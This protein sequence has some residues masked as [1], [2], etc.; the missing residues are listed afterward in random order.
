MST[1]KKADKLASLVTDAVFDESDDEQV[2]YT[3][4]LVY[5]GKTSIHI[6]ITSNLK[7]VTVVCYSLFLVIECIWRRLVRRRTEK[8]SEEEF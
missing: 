8:S 5:S 6:Y 3:H 4:I 7:Y 1:E 2:L